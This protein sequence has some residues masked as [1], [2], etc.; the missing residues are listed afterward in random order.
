MADLA[1]ADLPEEVLARF[2]DEAA[3]Q[4]AIDVALAVARRYCGW[5]VSPVVEETF[6]LDGSGGRVLS[7]P[8]MNLISVS[9]V[10]ENGVAV[11]VAKLDISRRKGTL[12][13]PFGKWTSRDGG[14]TVVCTHGYTEAEAADWRKA[15]IDL[16]DS[17]SQP[18]D[19]ERDSP[20]LILKRI[21]DVQYQWNASLPSTEERLASMLSQF[22]I[23]PAP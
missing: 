9:S 21:D 15:I 4:T 11:D 20:D 22:R 5:H 18:E 23:L 2:V 3:A 19:E 10:T 1:P 13:K 12:T 17:E 6:E 14:I 7:P 16:V 8:T